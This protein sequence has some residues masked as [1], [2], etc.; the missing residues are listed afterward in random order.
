MT[1]KATARLLP[2]MQLPD[3]WITCPFCFGHG[4]IEQ[5]EGPVLPCQP[6]EESGELVIFGVITHGQPRIHIA[7]TDVRAGGV[8]DR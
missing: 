7:G 5:R 8:V 4:F 3:A 2:N 6:C 1:D